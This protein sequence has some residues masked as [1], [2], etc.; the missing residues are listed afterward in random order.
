MSSGADGHTGLSPRGQLLEVLTK[1]DDGLLHQLKPLPMLAVADRA[2]PQ[3][4]RIRCCLRLYF[5]DRFGSCAT[6]SAR[7]L[8]S[9]LCGG[10]DSHEGV[11][12]GV[13]LVHSPSSR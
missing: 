11:A 13:E 12:D 1:I 7:V 3:R 9:A 2:A 5:L 6:A 10:N 8:V 4:M